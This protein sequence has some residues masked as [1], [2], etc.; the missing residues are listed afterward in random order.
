MKKEGGSSSPI[1]FLEQQKWYRKFWKIDL[2]E[3]L[4][5][6]GCLPVNKNCAE[7]WLKDSNHLNNCQ[8]LE[9]ESKE[10]Y[11]LFANSLQENKEKLE[12]CRC[13][14]SNKPRTPY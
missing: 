8:C 1:S 7:Q 4:E 3:W 5:N 10:T 6:Y 14:I 9:R 2:V 11:E 12:K 13:E